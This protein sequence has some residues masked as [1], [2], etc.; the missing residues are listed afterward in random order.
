MKQFLF[1]DQRSEHPVATPSL[2]LENHPGLENK[3][4]QSSVDVDMPKF[5]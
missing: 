4:K 2:F 1:F 5:T 3:V